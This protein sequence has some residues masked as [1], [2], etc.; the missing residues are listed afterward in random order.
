MKHDTDALCADLFDAGYAFGHL[1]DTPLASLTAGEAWREF[2]D[3]Y[4]DLVLDTFMADG[5]RYRYRRYAEFRCAGDPTQVS[6]LPHVPYEQ[7]LS[8]NPLNGGMQ[9]T[10]A[11]FLPS[12]ATGGVVKPVLAWLADLLTRRTGVPA[13][14][15]QCFQNRIWARDDE[16]GLPT[17]EGAHRDGVD[18]VLTLMVGR[19]NVAGG[20][21]TIYDGTGG[22]WPALTVE[23]T[24][25]GQVL[26]NDDHR[27]LHGVSPI[28]P[29]T[30]GRPG[31]RD[32]FIAI[33]TADPT[34]GRA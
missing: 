7:D 32:V 24:Q 15:A 34:E 28:V 3:S 30:P 33:L 22:E 2:A 29:Q 5:G 25:P 13:W 4:A 16:P 27:T 21:S 23:L 1:D 11:P 14:T 18:F 31:H 8:I 26:L 19:H 20:V 10:F 12:I 9:R 17:P 6:P